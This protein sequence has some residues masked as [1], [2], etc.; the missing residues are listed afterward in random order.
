[1]CPDGDLTCQPKSKWTMEEAR[2]AQCEARKKFEGNY[3]DSE[4]SCKRPKLDE[5]MLDGD[6]CNDPR[7]QCLPDQFVIEGEIDDGRPGGG[8][9]LP[10]PQP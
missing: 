1:M 4:R 5:G 7:A 6:I 10:P 3:L 9:G 8:G 2:E